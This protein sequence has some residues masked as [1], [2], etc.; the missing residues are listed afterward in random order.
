V[1]AKSVLSQLFHDI[2]NFRKRQ[3]CYLLLGGFAVAS[4]EMVTAAAVALMAAVVADPG[5]L[6]RLVAS[7][8]FLTHLIPAPT[9]DRVSVIL[10]TSMAT[11]VLLILKNA[12]TAAMAYVNAR[13]SALLDTFF[14]DEYLRGL[15]FLP[16]EWHLGRNS[17]ELFTTLL[18]RKHLGAGIVFMV[19]QTATDVMVTLLLIGGLLLATPL[20][21]LIVLMVMAGG[22]FLAFRFFRGYSDRTAESYKALELRVNRQGSQLLS[23][24]REVKIFGLEDAFLYEFSTL[25]RRCAL[26]EGTYRLLLRAPSIFFEVLGFLMLFGAI[27]MTVLTWRDSPST[28]IGVL[29]LVT[30]IAWR[31]LNAVNRILSSVSAIRLDLPYARKF[32]S[33]LEEARCVSPLS[34]PS[35]QLPPFTDKLEMSGVTFRYAGADK[36]A[37]DNV[38]F[39]VPRGTSLGLVGRSGAGKSTLMDILIGLLTPQAGEVR[40]DGRVLDRDV[41][42][43]WLSRIGYVSQTPYILDETLAHN[44][45][46]GQNPGS[47]DREKILSCCNMAHVDEFLGSLP[48]GL[49]TPI[50]EG[51][52]RL[53][54]GQR[55]RVAIARA[56]YRSPEILILD[57][58][59]SA[60]DAASENAIR[61]TVEQLAGTLTVIVIAHRLETVEHCQSVVWLDHG[62]LRLVGPPVEV[63]TAYRQEHRAAASSQLDHQADA[64]TPGGV[65]ATPRER[66]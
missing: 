41:L 37:I 7:H 25:S 5:A 29:A 45:A 48:Q 6:G 47:I 65:Q 31:V 53:S 34:A 43:S 14:G 39:V 57:E 54:G 15:L 30:V 3:A 66:D 4:L 62:R 50:G 60:L 26:K 38:S 61:R 52:A 44:I 46:F 13:F 16:Y 2:P 1:T 64:F 17:S 63:L 28:I 20:V 55:Q 32:F 58:A 22:A 49:D 33:L 19:I 10:F 12:G 40:V 23:G 21:S 36:S 24:I 59:T 42:P 8:P 11:G 18:W 9:V 35:M 51:G 27:A 56:L